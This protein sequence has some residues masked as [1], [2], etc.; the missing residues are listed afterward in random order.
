MRTLQQA[1]ATKDGIQHVLGMQGG[2]IVDVLLWEGLPKEGL[3]NGTQKCVSRCQEKQ[4]EVAL[5]KHQGIREY[6]TDRIKIGLKPI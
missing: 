1:R 5:R 3:E 2:R 4:G 6:N